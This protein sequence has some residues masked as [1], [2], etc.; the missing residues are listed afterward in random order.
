MR[1][2][3]HKLAVVSLVILIGFAFVGIFA[4]QI[5]PYGF[6]ELDLNNLTAS[7]TLKGWHLFGTDQLG[8][9]YLSRVIYGIRTS[10]WVA[11]MVAA[12]LSTFIGTVVGVDRRLLRRQGGQPVDALHRPHTHS[13]GARRAP[14]RRGVLRVRRSR[15]HA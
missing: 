12:L 1:F 13:A 11:V 2:F 10:L 5:A 4:S 8:R 14:H 7:P 6:D 3:R 9:D 15:Y